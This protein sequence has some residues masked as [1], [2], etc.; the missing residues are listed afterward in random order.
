[1]NKRFIHPV[2][3][4]FLL[5][6]AAALMS[7]VG[8]IY[9]WQGVQSLLSAEGMRWLLRNVVSLPWSASLIRHLFMLS[10][11]VGLC[12][13]SGWWA[14]CVR[15]ITRKGGLSRKER[16]AWVLSMA[17]W[18]MWFAFCAWLA[19]GSSAIVRSITG[20]LQ[21]SPFMSGLSFL[22]SLGL[23]LTAMI[24]GL[25]VDFYRTDRDVVKGISYCFSRFS[26]LWVALSFIALLL[27][28]LHY[29]GLDAWLKI[30]CLHSLVF[31]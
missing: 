9:S 6:L 5:T 2:T 31:F 28:I 10:F 16:R 18:V 19:F 1:M 20:G 15:L 22:C 14:L 4:L 24:Y 30:D 29:T 11:G 7:W 26:S 23:G 8:S 12:V 17:V 3:L 27:S 21:G 25:S 13:H